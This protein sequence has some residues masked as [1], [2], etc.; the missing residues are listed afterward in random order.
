MTVDNNTINMP[1]S[2]TILPNA[3]SGLEQG[4]QASTFLDKAVSAMFEKLEN[5]EALNPNS[6][7]AAMKRAG[8][9]PEALQKDAQFLLEEAALYELFSDWNDTSLVGLDVS[10][11]TVEAFAR[12]LCDQIDAAPGEV[13]RDGRSQVSAR[14][15]AEMSA[16]QMAEAMPGFEGLNDPAKDLLA[17]VMSTEYLVPSWLLDPGEKLPA[18]SLIL[19][20]VTSG[21]D[22]TPTF[23]ARMP[24]L[25]QVDN[26][27]EPVNGDDKFYLAVLSLST[28]EALRAEALGR[29]QIRSRPTGMYGYLPGST[30]RGANY[31]TT[32]L[33][34]LLATSEKFANCSVSLASRNGLETHFVLTSKQ[35]PPP[36]AS[37]LKS[38]F[39]SVGVSPPAAEI[40]Y[41]GPSQTA[42]FDKGMLVDP[43]GTILWDDSR[44]VRAH[45]EEAMEHLDIKVPQ[46]PCQEGSLSFSMDVYPDR[47]DPEVV[48]QL[49]QAV[50]KAFGRPM[51]ITYK[52]P[53]SEIGEQVG[54][55]A[56]AFGQAIEQA[57]GS[58]SS[59]ARS[60]SSFLDAKTQEG[61]DE[62][63]SVL[64]KW[65][66]R[67]LAKADKP[68]Q[69]EM[70]LFLSILED[71]GLDRE[72]RT[73]FEK[74]LQHIGPETTGQELL[75]G[76]ALAEVHSTEDPIFYS[77]GDEVQAAMS[78]ARETLYS[79]AIHGGFLSSRAQ[80]SIKPLFEAATIRQREKHS[81]MKRSEAY[82][83][84]FRTEM[85][86]R[87]TYE[88]R[89][90][91]RHSLR[92]RA[93]RLRG[94]IDALRQ[95][96]RHH[97]ALGEMR[98]ALRELRNEL[99]AAEREI[100]GA[101]DQ[102]QDA[103]EKLETVERLLNP[104]ELADQHADIGDVQSALETAGLSLPAG[105]D[106][107]RG[108]RDVS[109]DVLSLALAR[110]R[111]VQ[112]RLMDH[113]KSKARIYGGDFQRMADRATLHI[114]N[115]RF[116]I[117]VPFDQAPKDADRLVRTVAREIAE[118]IAVNQE[119][120]EFFTGATDDPEENLRRLSVSLCRSESEWIDERTS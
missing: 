71:E 54:E 26:I 98:L 6:V 15:R 41:E 65:L 44:T 72:T 21:P 83:E 4:G 117:Y 3:S 112:D 84:A 2:R 34:Q 37:D 7:R 32:D 11:E 30:P 110:V 108:V 9:A 109:S 1:S 16:D 5:S 59:T 46:F 31:S 68:V 20:P 39:E 101:W 63:R 42:V 18:G 118:L 43:D 33:E 102:W 74:V 10:G 25:D 76:L 73:A 62:R 45:L 56:S 77:A 115:E 107:H 49:K 93:D 12:L 87:R 24:T 79:Q 92:L 104:P 114:Q 82:R 69:R 75:C 48:P 29:F 52:F 60:M 103:K 99:G 86:A 27:D 88:T 97:P 91:V 53:T 94:R 47:L 64:A 100:P 119:L 80:S 35:F 61:R 58:F 90:G 23:S 95:V 55:T 105:F 40:R 67:C 50:E 51:K 22:G 70:P 28:R 36:S 85:R 8:V 78:E 81:K 13:R 38:F 113:L 66:S 96:N 17:S 120:R 14:S 111:E 19:E 106:L 89:V 116:Q 57:W